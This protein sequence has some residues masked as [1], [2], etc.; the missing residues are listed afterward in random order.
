MAEPGIRTKYE[1]TVAGVMQA[2]K[3]KVG[4]NPQMPL[5]E[6]ALLI[7]VGAN[8]VLEQIGKLKT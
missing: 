5:Q 4:L 6:N 1:V 2:V 7:W 3:V 8:K